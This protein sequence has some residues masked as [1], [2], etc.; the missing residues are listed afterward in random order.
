MLSQKDKLFSVN[1]CS[2]FFFFFKLFQVV[3][4]LSH[5]GECWIDDR[6][7]VQLWARVEGDIWN[8]SGE[9]LKNQNTV[10]KLMMHGS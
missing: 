3:H 6:C 2:F 1:I 4:L 9:H 5:S 10:L 8:D 7:L